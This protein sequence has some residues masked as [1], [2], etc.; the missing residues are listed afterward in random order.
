MNIGEVG[1]W[2]RYC[3]IVM[4]TRCFCSGRIIESYH[5]ES[6][7]KNVSATAWLNAH[8]NNRQIRVKWNAGSTNK[9]YIPSCKEKPE[10]FE[11]THV[12]C[13]R[14]LT[15]LHHPPFGLPYLDHV[16]SVICGSINRLDSR[17]NVFRMRSLMKGIWPRK[18]PNWWLWGYMR[19]EFRTD[20]ESLFNAIFA[21]FAPLP[22]PLLILPF[23]LPFC[24]HTPLS[25]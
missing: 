17:I 16:N 1:G 11:Y 20:F 4:C 15:S 12:T 10:A 8:I 22:F 6:K 19:V 18:D 5:C 21:S 14:S 23:L 24:S 2:V 7:R 25:A 3:V 9:N 13:P